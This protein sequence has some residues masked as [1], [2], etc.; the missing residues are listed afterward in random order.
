M[1][2]KITVI[3][4]LIIIVSCINAGDNT[5]VAPTSKISQEELIK[6]IQEFCRLNE[7][8]TN[9]EKQKIFD[10]AQI[11][12]NEQATKLNNEFNNCAHSKNCLSSK[13]LKETFTN[14]S[15]AEIAMTEAWNNLQDD[16][17]QQQIINIHKKY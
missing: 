15:K 16:G 10:N 5:P 1:N 9:S 12:R 17:V 4:L 11:Q 7:I 14:F 13:E 8:I 3:S 6:D 2:I